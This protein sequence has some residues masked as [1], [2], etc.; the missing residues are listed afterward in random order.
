MK[1]KK[2]AFKHKVYSNLKDLPKSVQKMVKRASK[3]TQFAYAPYSKFL[4]GAAILLEDGNIIGGCN[5]EN[6]SYPLCIC[7]ERVALYTYGAQKMK[8][9]IRALAV[10]AKYDLKPLLQPCMPCGACRQVIQEYENRQNKAIDIYA[11][12]EGIQEIIYF[13]GIETILPTAFSQATLL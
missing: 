3:Q 1:S 10:T 4:V 6:V 9:K 8:S 11:T 7:A 12:A 13:K 5:Q 2:P